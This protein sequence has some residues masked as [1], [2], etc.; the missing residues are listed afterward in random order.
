M[1]FM[2]GILSMW[3]VKYGNKNFISFVIFLLRVF[4]LV[5][6][7]YDTLKIVYF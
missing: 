7:S 2:I 3:Q 6:G 5:S 4:L 1:L